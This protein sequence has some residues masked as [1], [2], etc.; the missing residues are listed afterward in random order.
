MPAVSEESA[1]AGGFSSEEYALITESDQGYVF[2]FKTLEWWG[3][4]KAWLSGQG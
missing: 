3:M 4:C 2:R 1:P